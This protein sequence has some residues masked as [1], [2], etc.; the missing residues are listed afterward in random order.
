MRVTFGAVQRQASEGISRA[1]EQMVRFQRQVSTG[2]RVERP[3]DDPS[4]A[5]TAV[6][7]R[8]NLDSFSQFTAS[9][10][11]AESKLRVADS[12][13]S[14]L[15]DKLTAARSVVMSVR[16]STATD[17]QREASAEELRSLREAVIEDLNTAFRGTFLFGGAA[18][19][20][21]PFT[22]TNGVVDPYAGS[23]TE[24]AVDIDRGRSVTV[25]FDGSSIAQGGD[26]IDIFAAF[27]QAAAA[28]VAGDGTALGEAFDAMGRAFDRVTRAQTSV[29]ASL[30]AVA[31][32]KLRLGD[33]ARASGAR[34]STLEDANMVAA[35]SGM[36][37]A[38]VTYQA[39]LGAAARASQISLFDYLK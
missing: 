20:T 30:R 5:S 3:S 37:Q 32:H 21:K 33:A 39:A 18:G 25:A 36:N 2:K 16:G 10:D 14:D 29:G 1:S 12:V 13:M 22:V 23:T 24:V 35:I 6:S 8:A 19:D 26:A 7:E 4:A 17:A 9:A 27:D 31:D 11:A 15:L 28:A 34:L 38:E